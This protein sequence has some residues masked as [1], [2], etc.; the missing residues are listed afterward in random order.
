MPQPAPEHLRCVECGTLKPPEA[1]H[2]ERSRPSGRNRRCKECR[3]ARNREHVA[4][5]PARRRQS[6]D[7]WRQANPQR[8]IAAQRAYKLRSYGLTVEQYEAMLQRQGEVCAVCG[9]G[10]VGGWDLAVDHDHRT[11]HVRGLL[12]RR[13]NVGIGLLRDDPQLLAA[14]TRYLGSVASSRTTDEPLTDRT[15]A[16]TADAAPVTTKAMP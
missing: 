2:R 14:A 8:Y 9:E 3:N 13:C 15:T 5:D 12:C 1:F 11:G 6:M 7:R 4:K 16:A 10:E